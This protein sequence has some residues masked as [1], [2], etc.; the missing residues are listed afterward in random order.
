MI[1]SWPTLKTGPPSTVQM[2]GAE[3]M[4][5]MAGKVAQIAGKV[6]QIAVVVGL[7]VAD[8]PLRQFWPTPPFRW[9]I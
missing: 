2:A 9:S 8:V 7:R 4:A 3:K 6:A 1:V 5:Q